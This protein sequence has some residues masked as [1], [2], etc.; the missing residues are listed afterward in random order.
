MGSTFALALVPFISSSWTGEERCGQERGR[1]RAGLESFVSLHEATHT[2][3]LSQVWSSTESRGAFLPGTIG[4]MM[5]LGTQ[6]AFALHKEH[7]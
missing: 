4:L 2:K 7:C 6:I 5:L 3:G 1:S